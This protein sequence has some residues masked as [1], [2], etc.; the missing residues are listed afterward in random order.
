MDDQFSLAKSITEGTLDLLCPQMDLLVCPA[1]HDKALAGSGVIRAEDQGRLYFKMA[2]P[3]TGQPPPALRRTRPAGE[4]YDDHD[5]VVLRAIDQYGREWRSNWL[6]I[7]LTVP[8][9]TPS[10]FVRHNLEGVMHSRSQRLLKT[11]RMIL[12]IPRQNRLPFDGATTETRSVGDRQVSS[13]WR[14]DHHTRSFANAE[15]TF[16]DRGESWLTLTATRD[17]PIPPD[18]PGAMCQALEF[19]TA[20][21]ARPAVAVR[22]FN[23]REDIGLFS[24]PFWQYQSL[25]P[26]PVHPREPADAEGFWGLIQ[27]FFL[28][29]ASEGPNTKTATFL[30]ELAGIRSGATGSVQTAC[31]TLAIGVESLCSLLLPKPTATNTDS[32]DVRQLVG[33]LKTWKGDEVLK[34]RALDQIKQLSGAR[35]V[36]RLY[37]WA[38]EQGIDHALID[39]WKTL[40]HPKAHGKAL[41]EDQLLFDRYYAVVELLYRIV[42]W[43]IEYRGPI[44]PTSAR[45]WGG[46]PTDRTTPL[47]T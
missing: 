38:S 17:S 8:T 41:S 19:A 36:D 31:L 7:H 9:A 46:S 15:V 24:G 1:Y 5:H 43:A 28:F 27:R 39:R 3:F 47:E 26:P 6:L 30:D 21:R 2:A 4:V 35:T 33:Y 16:R 10:W 22:A 37:G 42:S 11:S 40:R 12:H 18:W 32:D 14:L 29:I 23:D 44:L 45:G 13:G 34:K 25:L 20:R